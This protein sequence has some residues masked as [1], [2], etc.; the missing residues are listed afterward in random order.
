MDVRGFQTLVKQPLRIANFSG[1]SF[2]LSHI[3]LREISTPKS[4]FVE[5]FKLARNKSVKS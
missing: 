3:E 2:L 4:G 5:L 1:V